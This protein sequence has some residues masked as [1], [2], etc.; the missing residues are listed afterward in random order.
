MS[1]VSHSIIMSQLGFVPSRPIEPQQPGASSGITALPSSAFET[2]APRIS[3][4]SST[5]SVAPSAPAPTS[6]A[7]F[8][9]AFKISAAR[10]RSASPGTT[11]GVQ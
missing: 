9:P 2:P 6:I 11:R 3:A 8:S 5:S 7:T 1:S 4:T 10:R